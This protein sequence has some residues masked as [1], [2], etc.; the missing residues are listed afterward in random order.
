MP[1]PA[2]LANDGWWLCERHSTMPV[3]SFPLQKGSAT[4]SDF[5]APASGAG[6]VQ[7]HAFPLKPAIALALAALADWVFYDHQIGISAVV[8]ALALM[9]GSTL[10]NLA[11]WEKK[12]A[13]LTVILVLLGLL[14][15]LEEFNTISLTF[16]ILTLGVSIQLAAN[17]GFERLGQRASAL[18]DLYLFGPF[19]FF[20][21]AAGMFH[22]PTIM[23][24][25]AAW[26][27]PV[28]L[29]GVFVF[30][31][32]SAN[33]L[34]EKWIRFV[35]PGSAPSY[36]SVGRTLFWVVAL[37]LVWPFIHVQW[38]GR[39]RVTIEPEA[40]AHPQATSS[41]GVRFFGLA[42]TLRSLILFNLLFAVQTVL[43]AVYLWG[44]TTLPADIGY[45]SYAHRGAYPLILTALLAA[46]FVLGTMRPGG[47]AER[48]KVIRLLVYLWVAQNVLLVA[49]SILRLDLYVQLYLLTWWRVAAFIWMLLVMA[50]LMLIVARIVLNRS[51]DWLI[52]ANLITLAATLYICSLMN[53]TALIADYNVNH[54]RE[55]SGKGVAIDMNYLFHL[56]PQALPAIDKAIT[57]RGFDPALVSRR[58]CLVEQQRKDMASWRAWSFR[59]WRLQRIL[60]AQQKTTG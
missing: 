31:F 21:E 19:R 50:G 44:N 3:R 41:N 6:S 14:P 24:G 22:L 39:S 32:A 59:S 57:L 58:G 26:F 20:R 47:P 36:L 60:D 38:R 42:T 9:S 13:L 43:D 56:G 35:T 16:I 46:G 11:T 37:S 2:R 12:Q 7:E 52:G 23:A 34:I 8:F 40:T 5:T 17:P 49:S 45:A 18:R 48:S 29:G 27:I 28:V 15:A 30:L 53:I 25:I 51:N 1:I 54:S 33:P 55:A 10:A 4:M